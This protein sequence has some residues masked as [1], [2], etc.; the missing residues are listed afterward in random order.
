MPHYI[1]YLAVVFPNGDEILANTTIIRW[2]HGADTLQHPII[3]SV[4]YSPDNG[5][6]WTLLATNLSEDNYEWDT[7][8]VNDGSNYLI[9]VVAICSEGLAVEDISD[10]TFTIQNAPIETRPTITPT[11]TLSIPTPFAE[12]AVL[13]F[14]I[15]ILAIITRRRVKNKNF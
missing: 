11:P 7:T 4:Y 14:S 9:K 2:V 1:V 10:S 8:S 12:F 3:Y 13:I 5:D 15:S 6:S